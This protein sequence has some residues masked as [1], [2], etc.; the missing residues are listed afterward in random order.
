MIHFGINMFLVL[1]YI[2]NLSLYVDPKGAGDY[3]VLSGQAIT[4]MQRK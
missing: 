1:T 4:L 3:F 2:N